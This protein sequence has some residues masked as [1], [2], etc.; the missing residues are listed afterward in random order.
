MKQKNWLLLLHVFSLFITKTCI[1]TCIFKISS[2]FVGWMIPCVTNSVIVRS[3]DD[4][5]T[6]VKKVLNL[7]LYALSYPLVFAKHLVLCR[8]SGYVT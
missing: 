5:F 3:S 7:S 1:V 4:C 2:E 8:V 6:I